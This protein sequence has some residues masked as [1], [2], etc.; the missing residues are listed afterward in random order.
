MDRGLV[1]ARR[2]LC[3]ALIGALAA[4]AVVS[5]AV[6]MPSAPAS[7]ATG[8]PDGRT[9]ETAAG[10]CWEIK[11]NEPEAQSGVYWLVTPQLVAPQQ[12]YCDQTTDGGGWVLIGRGRE[13]WKQG[14]DGVGTAENLR[15][16]PSGVAAFAPAQLPGKTV[17]GLLGGGRVDA[18]PDGIRLRRAYNIGGTQW[19]EARF[20]LAK[21]DRWVWTFG[22]EHAVKSYR[23]E[24]PQGTVTGSGGTTHKF[25]PD[26]GYRSVNFSEISEYAANSLA[27]RFR[28]GWSYSLDSAGNAD[29]ASYLW[30]PEEQGFARPFTQV[31]LR[32]QLKRDDLDFGTIAPTGAP[33]QTLTPLPE[34][35]A[36]RTTWGVSGLANGS[37][38]E[39]STEVARFGQVGGTVFVGGNFRYVQRT[40]AG[41]GR[42]DQPYLAGF[43]VDTGEWVSTFRPTL[44]GQVKAIAGLPDGRVAIGGQ[45]RTVNGVPQAGLAFLDPVTGQLSGPQ[46]TVEHR[47]TGAIPFV[48]DVDVQDGFLY[49]A[50]AFTHLR[51][52]GSA[53]SAAAWNGGRIDLSTSL[54]DTSWNAQLNGTTMSV[55]ASDRGDR[56]YYSGYFRMKGATLALS[57]TALQTATGAPLVTPAWTPSFSAYTLDDAHQPTGNIWQNA[58]HEVGDRVWLG[59][60]QHALFSYDRNTFA[61]QS[62]NIALL[63][64]DFQTV[65]TNADS[66]LVIGGCHCGDWVYEDAY[67]YVYPYKQATQADKISLVGAWDAKTGRYDY[68]WSPTLQSRVGYGAWGTFFDSTGVLWVGGD[69]SRSLRAG[70]A[71]QWSGGFARFAPRDSTAP[72]TPGPISAT[73]SGDGS[74]STLAWGAVTGSG[75]VTY[76]VMQG[77]RVIASTTATTYTVPDPSEP[78]GYFVRARDTAGNRSATTAEFVLQP[79]APSEMTLIADGS[80]WTWRY[81]SETLPENWT[82]TTF[83]DTSWHSGK[84]SFGR[85]TDAVTTDIDPTDLDPK[86]LSA[87][88]RHTF[89]VRDA[90]SVV[91]GKISVIAN[92]GVV[93]WLNG[94]ELTR[95]RMPDGPVTQ[96]TIATGATSHR[97]ALANR[98]VFDVP[99]GLLVDG[100]NVLAASVHANYRAT[101]DLSF[102]L[103]YTARR[104]VALEAVRDLAAE[105]TPLGV[106]LSWTAPTE[107]V[108][109]DAYIVT[110]GGAEVATVAAPATSF[111]DTELTAATE[112]EYSVAAA[113]ADGMTSEPVKAQVTTAPEPPAEPDADTDPDAGSEPGDGADPGDS[114]NPDDNGTPGDSATP[115]DNGG[116][117]DSTT[118]DAHPGDEGDAG[119]AADAGGMDDADG[120]SDAAGER[121]AGVIGDGATPGDDTDGIRVDPGATWSWHSSP[122]PWADDWNA[123]DFDDSYWS[124]GTAPFGRG[125]PDAATD[126]TLPDAPQQPLSAQFRHAFTVDDPRGLE[127]GTVAVTADDGVAVFLNGVELGRANLPEGPL[128]QNSS[129]T[130][131][132]CSGT[133]ESESV[134]FRVPADL[135][136][137]GKNVLAV[138]VHAHDRET[139]DLS[140]DLSLSV[141]RG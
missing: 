87:Q 117:G 86:P 60:S 85:G 22:A 106:T 9:Q 36:M 21:R 44:D 122:Q 20:S 29:P 57:A 42:V 107:G 110:R 28:A 58:V 2:R 50:G 139:P 55:D 95:V 33:A 130:A 68:E 76:E 41:D 45:F 18:L 136:R 67:S 84:G 52:T 81:S 23:F 70:G 90:R 12:F 6:V 19:Q 17:D 26:F 116:P 137:K 38:K 53:T 126:M 48:R 132:P 69:V 1:F 113:T 141:P 37:T 47:A 75:A 54:P 62:G 112:Y 129:A 114:A 4:A 13:G 89:D 111:T 80:T 99:P 88:F 10:S 102:E 127:D 83:D 72:G 134:T 79:P 78:T 74:T 121:D 131:A 5:G 11:Q 101:R 105:A 104:A 27:F 94:T 120:M 100:K 71:L 43:A 93:L 119:C 138:S 124:T 49:V 115:D 65:E 24:D 16:T 73:P 91:D 103:S 35:T 123:R 82:A 128:T 34:N 125:V 77:G 133:A 30:S 96:D 118:P 31:Y 32:P 8:A 108:A 109:P 98:V 61:L 14:Y 92:D 51:A 25:G 59:G 56:T 39:S 40:E 66:S 46:V 7:A 140:F 135:L 3:R 97:N 15:E 63:G 64:G